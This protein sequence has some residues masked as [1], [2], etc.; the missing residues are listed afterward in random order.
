MVHV[1]KTSVAVE[2]IGV[3]MLLSKFNPSRGRREVQVYE[4]GIKSA[5]AKLLKVKDKNIQITNLLE[6]D[7]STERITLTLYG[8]NLTSYLE[9]YKWNGLADEIIKERG[10]LLLRLSLLY[11]HPNKSNNF[12][13]DENI[14]SIDNG[15]MSVSKLD[16]LCP[17]GQSLSDNGFICG[18]FTIILSE[19][20]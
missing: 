3:T 11:M 5:L 7:D 16:P 17:H 12:T 1:L 8:R 15:L 13:A 18:K 2:R 14:Y 10:N 4:R 20:I 9:T 6:E 19:I